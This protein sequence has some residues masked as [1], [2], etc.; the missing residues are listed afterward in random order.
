MEPRLHGANVV[1]TRNSRLRGA[2]VVFT[3][4]TR[5]HGANGISWITIVWIRF[6]LLI[7]RQ[8]LQVAGAYE[9]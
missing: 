2:T 3:R 4:N 1:F 5:L 9:M 7:I 6:L 8:F